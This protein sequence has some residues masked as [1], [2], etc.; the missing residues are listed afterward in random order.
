MERTSV[1]LGQP[2]DTEQLQIDAELVIT[3]EFDGTR[4]TSFTVDAAIDRPDPGPVIAGPPA[5]QRY[6]FAMQLAGDP[7][8]VDARLSAMRETAARMLLAGA[9]A[10]ELPVAAA[11]LA[12]DPEVQKPSNQLNQ[13]ARRALDVLAAGLADP[14]FVDRAAKRLFPPGTDRGHLASAGDA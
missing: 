12:E 9:A 14:G 10:T 2:T 11:K 7:L 13:T 4:L 8:H 5:Q 3:L 6:R 1:L